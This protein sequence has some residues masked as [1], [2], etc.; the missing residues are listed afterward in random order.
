MLSDLEPQQA[1][2]YYEFKPRLVDGAFEGEVDNARKTSVSLAA[3]VL[4]CFFL[5]WV[6]LSCLGVRDSVSGYDLARAGDKV[7]WLVPILMLFIV[8]LGLSRF[9]WEKM[10]AI[11]GLS[12]TLGGSISAYLMYHE[13]S[14]TNHSPRLVP[15]Q[16]TVFF[17][18]DF[19]ACLC[20]VAAGFAFYIK[21][22]RSS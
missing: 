11:L 22:S 8:I 3:F 18:L 16:W 4:L 13:R 14:S 17:W 1:M 2:A 15:T 5:P 21:R 10:P 9:I 12:M 6:E 20:V 19:L 7:L